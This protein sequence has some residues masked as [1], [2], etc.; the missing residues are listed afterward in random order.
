MT[1]QKIEVALPDLGVQ[2][3]LKLIDSLKTL[4]AGIVQALKTAIALAKLL[5][6]PY[7]AIMERL[8]KA[9]EDTIKSL[10][11]DAGGYM[12]HVPIGKRLMTSFNNL[13]DITP[14]LGASAGFFDEPA[15]V[16][17]YITPAMREF[18]TDVN[19]YSGGNAGFYR[20]MAAS[21]EDLG[22]VNRPQFTSP[23]DYIGGLVLIAGTSADPLG[24]LEDLWNFHLL[25]GG[26][27]PTVKVPRPMGLTAKTLQGV[28]AGK[29]SIFLTWNPPTSP[30]TTL[31]DLGGAV[32]YAREYAVIRCKNYTAAI[33]AQTVV[34]LLGTRDIRE[35]LTARDGDIEVV[36]VGPYDITKTCYTD[37]KVP[38]T[39][40]DVFYY[41]VAWKLKAFRPDESLSENGGKNLNWWHISNIARVTPL[42]SLPASTPPDWR[43]TRS[44]GDILPPLANVLYRVL[45]VI[46][47]FQE[48]L[49][50][51][52]I[53]GEA[54]LEFLEAEID[55]YNRLATDILDQIAKLAA[56]MQLPTSGLYARFFYGKGG[57]TFLMQEIAK[58]FSAD[59]K[60]RPPFDK[61][62]EYVTGLVLLAGGPAPDVKAFLKTIS[63]IF[64]NPDMGNREVL[65]E[66]GDT[67]TGMEELF[68]ADDMSLTDAA[69]RPITFTKDMCPLCPDDPCSPASPDAVTLSADMKVVT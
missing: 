2:P 63:W 27:D 15:G 58:G 20:L 8:V 9:L 45:S 43:R 5:D 10:V 52:A 25:F 32:L 18:W 44:I 7:I 53:A 51:G 16:T 42:A 50:S 56:Y 46:K 48:R 4:L 40:D 49:K 28:T 31:R 11:E 41:A 61:G 47:T 6:D 29:C 55:R 21:L 26:P 19:R 1:W 62:S 14:E 33:T 36:H 66:L 17:K 3:L 37:S 13:G 68:Y 54:Y 35:G 67:L 38:A 39:E 64:G 30:I 23:D 34:D 59:E 65:R 24:F 57:N 60:N 12:L 69:P 22:D